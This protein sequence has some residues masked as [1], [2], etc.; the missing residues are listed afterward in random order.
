MGLC[1]RWREWLSL[2]AILVVASAGNAWAQTGTGTLTGAVR[3]SQGGVIPGATVTATNPA[4]GAARM[5]S[6]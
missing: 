4:T 6:R 3:D 5:N 1:V 2:I